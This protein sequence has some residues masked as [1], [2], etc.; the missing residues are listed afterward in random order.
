VIQNLVISD[1]I[2]DKERPMIHQPPALSIYHLSPSKRGHLMRTV[3]NSVL[4][5]AYL[6]SMLSISRVFIDIIH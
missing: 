6:I 2:S 4:S 5:N 1:E 3:Q